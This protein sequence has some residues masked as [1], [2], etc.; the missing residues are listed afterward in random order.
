MLVINKDPN[1]GL[2]FD[3]NK[4]SNLEHPVGFF[5]DQNF[6]HRKFLHTVHGGNP[7]TRWLDHTVGFFFFT[8]TTFKDLVY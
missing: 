5:F 6:Y 1:K 7:A 3:P 2:L 8:T 4:G